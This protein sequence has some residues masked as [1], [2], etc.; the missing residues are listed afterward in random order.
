[1]SDVRG[2]ARPSLSRHIFSLRTLVS[3]A[4]AIGFVALLVV[5]FRVDWAKTWD[6][7]QALDFRL[8]AA[9]IGVYYLTFIVRG[10]R[11]KILADNAGLGDSPRANQPSVLYFSR[12]ILIGWFVN[13]IAPLRLGDAY[14]AYA[15]SARSG[16]GFSWSLGTILAERFVDM[17]SVLVLVVVA[18]LWY[19]AVSDIG[20]I[21]YVVLAAIL[22]AAAL[23]ALLLLMRGYGPR[24]AQ[25]LPVRFQGA[26][27]RFQQGTLGSLSHRR[28]P[29]V[30]VLGMVAW[31]FEVARIQLV[32]E[33]M[34]LSVVLPLVVLAALGHAIL[35]TVPSPGGVGAV[36]AGL[37]GLLVLDLPRADAVSVALVD[38]TITYVSVVAFGGL[39]LLLSEIARRRRGDAPDADR[40]AASA[41]DASGNDLQTPGQ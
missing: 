16:G 9:A 19:S 12:L 8:Y 7:L 22:M 37:V 11:W 24:A 4:I 23:G 39:A 14:R 17:I 28:R 21:A 33:A 38:R 35:S 34:D 41:S 36:E 26:Y 1:M 27:R 10:L 20:V 32:V 40:P 3:F 29:S 5:T 30:L 2:P 13:G 25:Y 18:V 31:L 6:N 15:L